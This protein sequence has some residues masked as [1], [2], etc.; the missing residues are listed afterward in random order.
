MYELRTISLQ[1]WYLCDGDDVPLRGSVGIVGPTGA[2]KSSLLDAVQTVMCGGS[3]NSLHLNASSDLPSDRSV[4]EYCLGYL[5]PKKDG[6]NPKRASCE[7][8]IALTF[9]EERKD[10]TKHDVTIG[11]A[12]SAREGDSRETVLSRF[13]APGYA[14]TV[15]DWWDPDEKDVLMTWDGIVRGL[16]EKSGDL[17]EYKSNSTAIAFVADVLATLRP[18]ARQPNAKQFLHAFRTALKFKPISD[19]TQFVRSTI[20][21][22][23]DLDV[24]RVRETVAMWKQLS[25]AARQIEEKIERVRTVSRA[26]DAWGT[27]LLERVEA[28][29]LKA[30]A[31]V[32]RRLLEYMLSR[33]SLRAAAEAVADMERTKQG[34]ARILREHE[35]DLIA[36]NAEFAKTGTQGVLTQIETERR[37]LGKETDDVQ[38]QVDG[39]REALRM[40]SKISAARDHLP[41]S[42]VPVIAAA[43]AALA[44][45]GAKPGL[46][47]LAHNAPAV[48]GHAEKLKGLAA[49]PER[50]AP[51]RE[52]L[53]AELTDLRR[54]RDEI[55]GNLKRIREGGSSLGTHTLSYLRLLKAADIEAVPLCEVVEVTDESW[56]FAVEAILGLGREAVIVDPSKVRHA[57]EILYR[58]RNQGLHL[59]RLVKTERTAGV[60]RSRPGS[61]ASVVS[62]SNPHAQAYV[63]THLGGYRLVED[64]DGLSRENRAIMRNGKT[65]SGLDYRV[66][67]DQGWTPLIGRNARE[68]SRARLAGELETV[69]REIAVKHAAESKLA[70]AAIAAAQASTF[71]VDLDTLAFEHGE[72]QRKA[73]LLDA[74]QAEAVSDEE[75]D[76][77]EEIGELKELIA[78]HRAELDDL[79]DEIKKRVLAHGKLGGEVE[80]S[81]KRLRDSVAEKRG[82]MQD[83]ADADVA[84]VGKLRATREGKEFKGATNPFADERKAGKAE[85]QA[86]VARHRQAEG[87]AAERLSRADGAA[88][89]RLAGQARKHLDD[90][91]RD[92][93]IDPELGQD[94]PYHRDLYWVVRHLQRLEDHELREYR[95]KTEAAERAMVLAIKEDLLTKLAD[96]FRKLDDQLR[97]LNRRLRQH[98]FTG[99]IYRFARKPDPALDKTRRLAVEVN[100]KPEIAQAIIEKRHDDPVLKEAMANLEAYLEASGSEGLEDYRR[101]FTF[102]LIMQPAD[103]PDDGDDAVD[104]GTEGNRMSL[105]A[106]AAVASGGEGQAPYYVAMGAAMAMA[107]FPDGHPGGEPSGFGLTMFDEA[108]N[109]LDIPNTQALIR[110]FKDMGLQLVV[111]APE[112]ARTTL[113]EVMDTITTVSKSEATMSVYIGSQY[114]KE[115]ARRELRAINPHHKGVE[116]F[117]AEL[118][119]KG[120]V[121]AAD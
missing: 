16:R 90:Y 103:Q 43:D 65:S 114:P 104:A 119:R 62:T 4:L 39:L 50:L 29:W 7:T 2:G 79:D 31:T 80:N 36:K 22:Q 68:E 12:M 8:V 11:V 45:I 9:T 17:L 100:E 37:L 86:A 26:Y 74:R 30:C 112:G 82:A 38:R 99:Q 75:R 49:L 91:C 116:G 35:D 57:N 85:P 14:Y 6:G 55:E 92:W 28:R 64:E 111:A 71:S 51:Q 25:A 118:A 115:R 81:R 98:R 32:E 78:A 77:V 76:L 41:Q 120:K 96:K 102:D 72:I 59:C 88:V 13:I 40:A 67:R 69:T 1:N 15:E 89:Q 46:D 101:Y 113:T 63:D 84:A 121:A 108:F 34:Q 117:R 94:P 42:F 60:A 110:F 44:I 5:K 93:A 23:D 56:Q 21:E 19:P 105:S 27:A 24:A 54:R 73:K 20:L 52:A 106:R 47:W 58:N 33:A 95:E 66:H 53:S 48:K 97:A 61:L 18:R 87:Q 107:Y 70:Q 10:G 83:F 3:H 109:K